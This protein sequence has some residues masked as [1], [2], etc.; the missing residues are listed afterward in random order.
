MGVTKEELDSREVELVT[1][2]EELRH[3]K[4][5]A[6]R[7]QRE[8]LEF[9]QNGV[10]QGARFAQT[11]LQEGTVAEIVST[12]TQVVSR[13]ETLE[14]LLRRCL[15]EPVTSTFI[16]FS[17]KKVTPEEEKAAEAPPT[18]P[19]PTPPPIVK[20][21]GEIIADHPFKYTISE[22]TVLTDLLYESHSDDYDDTGGWNGNFD[23]DPDGHL[24][25][26]AFEGY[27]DE[28]DQYIEDEWGNPGGFEDQES[29]FGEEREGGYD[30]G[31]ESEEGDEEEG[32]EREEEYAGAQWGEPWHENDGWN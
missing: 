23:D 18:T 5:K 30:D 14:E 10:Q 13:L 28:N 21:L 27:D 15:F 17:E 22:E 26:E 12:G 3:G 16:T 4:D 2:V 9:V 19:T 11:L 25:E 20:G 31:Q 24:D 32:E 29:D 6:L 8:E 7:I 1:E